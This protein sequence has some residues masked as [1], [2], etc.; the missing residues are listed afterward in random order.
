MSHPT[1]GTE[2]IDHYGNEK[3]R[4]MLEYSVKFYKA[5]VSKKPC[6]NREAP[7]DFTI[8]L[9]KDYYQMPDDPSYTPPPPPRIEGDSPGTF[10]VQRDTGHLTRADCH[11][12]PKGRRKDAPGTIADGYWKLLML[13]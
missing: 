3:G 10:K 11:S 13:R 5:R 8:I 2:I 4:Q 12:A 9:A 6:D 1:P 7:S